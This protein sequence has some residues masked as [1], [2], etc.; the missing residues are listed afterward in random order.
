MI[1]P[2]KF[3][4]DPIWYDGALGFLEERRLNNKMSCDIGSVP[5]PNII[6]TDKTEIIM[7]RLPTI[8][9][10]QDHYD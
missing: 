6:R 7:V 10:W 9:Q 3:H 4:P 8:A 2:V 5:D 1:N